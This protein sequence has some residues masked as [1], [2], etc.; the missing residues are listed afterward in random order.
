LG[1]R[2]KNVVAGLAGVDMGYRDFELIVRRF[3][4]EVEREGWV[5]EFLEFYTGR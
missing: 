4:E 1:V 2:V 5:R 3:V